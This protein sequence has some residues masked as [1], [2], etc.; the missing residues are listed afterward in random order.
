VAAGSATASPLDHAQRAVGLRLDRH[1]WGSTRPG[2]TSEADASRPRTTCCSRTA[3]RS[4]P[5]RARRPARRS[6][7]RSTSPRVSRRPT[8][9]RTRPRCQRRR[10]RQPLVPRP[11]LPR[12]VSR[13]PARAHELVAPPSRRRPRAIARRSTSSASTTTS[14]SSSRPAPTAARSS[15]PGRAAHGHGLGG[16]S[17]RRC[18]RCSSASRGLRAR[19]DLHHGERRRFGDVRV[20]DGAS[21]TRA[22]GV[23]RVAHR[24]VGRRSRRRRP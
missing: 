6:G 2:R 4:R 24:A 11:D 14:A 1:C 12:L 20:H 3:G 8:R 21:T 15:R 7:S 22:D 9:P 19:G 16:L 13:R 23:P 5:I 17:R 18:T 10:R